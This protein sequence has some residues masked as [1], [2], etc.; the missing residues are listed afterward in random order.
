MGGQTPNNIAMPMHRLGVPILGTSAESIDNAEN[1]FK[2]SRLLDCIGLSQPR[3]KELTDI[4][5]AK[6]FCEE[7][8]YPC[9]VR[10][11]YVLS[12]AAMNVANDH[13][14][15][16]TFLTAAKNISPEHPVVISQFILDAKEID[17]DAVA[18]SGRLVAM[19]VSEHVENAGVHSGDATLVTPPQDLNEETL[20]LIKEL[21]RALAD[22]LEVSGPFNLQLLAKDNRLLIIEANL[23]VSRSFPFVSKTL[24][25]DFIAAA[26]RAI[27]GAA[28]DSI[29][30]PFDTH[31]SKPERLSLSK[32]FLEPSVNV[33]E[34]TVGYVGVKVPVFSFARLLGADVLLGVEMVSTGEVACFGVDRYEAYLLA[35]AAALCNT[36]GLLPKPGDNV[37]LSIGSYRH[38]LEML[39]SVKQLHLLGYKLYGSCGT[40]DFYQT[41]GISII[42]VEW[43]YEESDISIFDNK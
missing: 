41:Q 40:A 36:N 16:I 23:R 34:N 39:P 42:P 17:V 11:S 15:L 32:A 8:G 33:L 19:A 28:R 22:E 37:F 18:Q 29:H 43:P 30:P 10:P 14:Q 31:S 1:R 13:D 5:S 4:D 27:L 6:A 20:K 12:G 2:F 24:K 21:V 7:V 3:W 26:T 38:K 35:Q 9:L 25:Y